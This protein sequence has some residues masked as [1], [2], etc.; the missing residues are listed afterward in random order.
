MLKRNKKFNQIYDI[1]LI[2][3][4]VSEIDTSGSLSKSQYES[5]QRLQTLLLRHTLTFCRKYNKKL[6]FLGRYDL[7]RISDH[8][9]KEEEILFYKYK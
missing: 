9:N 7:S 6:L 8:L 2:S 5:Q 4:A 1:C 3:E